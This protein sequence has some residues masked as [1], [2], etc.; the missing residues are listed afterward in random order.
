MINKEKIERKKKEIKVTVRFDDL[1]DKS[2]KFMTGFPS[3]AAM[4]C[5]TILVC[6][7]DVT[8]MTTKTVTTLTCYI[9]HSSA[10]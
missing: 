3:I 10:T 4:L 7:G 1:D 9:Q 2:L 6:D 5:F 8:I